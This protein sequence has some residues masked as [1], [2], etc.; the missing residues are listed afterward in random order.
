MT[1]YIRR[2]LGRRRARRLHR[3]GLP[4][5]EAFFVL[6]NSGFSLL[7]SIMFWR[8]LTGAPFRKAIQTVV[9]SDTWADERPLLRDPGGFPAGAEGDG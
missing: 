3:A 7:E 8:S 2:T 5:D 1:R 4:A 9:E 6:R